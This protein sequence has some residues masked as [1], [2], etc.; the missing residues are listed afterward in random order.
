MASRSNW[1]AC[2]DTDGERSTGVPLTGPGVHFVHGRDGLAAASFGLRFGGPAL[3][4]T[5][6]RMLA[7]CPERQ[8]DW[9]DFCGVDYIAI[10]AL[11][12]LAPCSMSVRRHGML[13][14]YGTIVITGGPSP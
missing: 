12:G 11:A 10:G 6:G 1:C 9:L 5:I 2:A 13:R 3:G 8:S 14:I 4:A 7:N